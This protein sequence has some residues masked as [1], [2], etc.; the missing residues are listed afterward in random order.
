MTKDRGLRRA[1]GLRARANGDFGNAR[2]LWIVAHPPGEV[3]VLVACATVCDHDECEDIDSG[4]NVEPAD[5]VHRSERAQGR[6]LG[7]V[8]GEVVRPERLADRCRRQRLVGADPALDLLQRADKSRGLSPIRSAS[9]RCVH[10]DSEPCQ[11]TSHRAEVSA[12]GC[13]LDHEENRRLK[14]AGSEIVRTDCVSGAMTRTQL[15]TVVVPV[16]NHAAFVGEALRSVFRQDGPP[17]ELIVIDDGST[18]GSAEAVRAVL[19]EAPAR[20]SVRFVSRENRGAP[21]TI[22][23]GLAMA[24]GAWL[25]IL[26]SDDAY[27]PSRLARAVDALERSG[28]RL[29]FSQVR[30]I[31]AS[32]AALGAAH[33]WQQWYR[34]VVLRRLPEA[35]SLSTLLLSYNAAVSTGNLVF[36]RDL[37]D[38]IG[39]F[40]PYR[41]AHDVDFVLR[42]CLVAEPVLL[43]EPLY[44]YRVHA[45]NTIADRDQETSAEYETIVAS[46]LQATLRGA[47]TNPLAPSLEAYAH[48]LGAE[49]A[50]APAHVARALDRLVPAPAEI[51]GARA[52]SS[53]PPQA[54]PLG[55][56]EGARIALIAPDPCDPRAAELIGGFAAA[57]AAEGAEVFGLAPANA[58]RGRLKALGCAILEEHRLARRAHSAS[59][60]FDTIAQAVARVGLIEG[61]SRRLAAHARSAGARFRA[62]GHVRGAP[63]SAL[64]VYGRAAIAGALPVAER[65]PGPI[66][67]YVDAGADPVL[68]TREAMEPRLQALASSG[69]LHLLFDCG[70]TRRA[71]RPLGYDGPVR[72][73]SGIPAA[74]GT[75][76]STLPMD[77][78][79]IVAQWGAGSRAL[80][81]AFAAARGRGL[82]SPAS[83]LRFLDCGRPSA[84]PGVL[85]A[86]ARAAR[87]DLRGAVTLTGT[88]SEAETLAIYR[89][90]TLYAHAGGGGLTRPLL[91]AMAHA[92]PILA[93]APGCEDAV[94]HGRTGMLLPACAV[95]AAAEALGRLA[96]DASMARAC[97]AAARA[98]FLERFSIEA[99]IGP[100]LDALRGAAR[101]RSALEGESAG[102]DGGASGL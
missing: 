21:A 62:A 93:T 29:L 59:R 50:R 72:Y 55:R 27:G 86:M 96:G 7:E 3:L 8:G 11:N 77:A 79:V 26:N 5:P 60:A 74:C 24:S 25:T 92:L 30:A 76:G 38:E 69:R 31:D 66:F 33:P 19:A 17:I 41:F 68:D 85:D 32:G 83:R 6:V 84:V 18:D 43:R 81:E 12:G 97:G 98:R 39:G 67:W 61:P 15:V 36:A 48:G 10:P 34:D 44:A 63:N 37:Y 53:S 94:E 40:A 49:L 14:L 100:L 2:A 73:W 89:S 46:Y 82:L 78:P 95:D 88:G 101:P 42:A 58:L 54:T 52:A 45:A 28:A 80:L 35:P 70:E 13:A 91:L 51:A 57:A 16:Y 4:A 9:Y 87:A 22:N 102:L 23:E 56:G 64:L 47:R 20:I 1:T 71:W 90:A 99:T 65:W 75:S